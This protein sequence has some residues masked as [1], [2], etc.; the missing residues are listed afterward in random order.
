MS[1][2]CAALG[3]PEISTGT[4]RKNHLRSPTVWVNVE[5][6]LLGTDSR[7]VWCAFSGF[8]DLERILMFP[9]AGFPLGKCNSY[10]SVGV[11]W[12]MFH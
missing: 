10:R 1:V 8:M 4:T 2:R 6:L 3:R 5:L 7:V 11:A 12:N 9:F